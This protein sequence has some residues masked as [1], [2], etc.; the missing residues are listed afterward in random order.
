MKS[1]TPFLVVLALCASSTS[2]AASSAD[3]LKVVATIPDLA[4]VVEQIGGDRVDVTAITR[5]RENLHAVTARPSHL[6]AMSRADLFVQIGLSLETT[7]VPGLLEGSRNKAIRPGAPGFVNT[8]DGWEAIDV[9][10]SLSRQGGD[11]HPQGNPHLNLDPRGGEQ[12]AK[13]IFEALVNLDPGSKDAYGQRYDAYRSK[14]ALAKQRWDGL[15][16]HFRGKQVAVYHQEFDYFTRYYEMEI[17][18]RIELRPGIP[19]TPNHMAKVIADMKSQGVEVILIAGWSKN[20]DVERVAEA[21]GA[22]V[23]ELPNQVDG[24][25]G[26]DTWIGMMD[27]VHERIA[28]VFGGADGE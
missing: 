6:V 22:T 15:A 8:S 7:F 9:P 17:V 11:L 13:A 10:A 20:N 2:T 21:T 24:L 26:A 25:A 5:G 14:L 18:D 4:D 23:V 16:K 12:M 19:P 1:F 27:L 28:A 3:E